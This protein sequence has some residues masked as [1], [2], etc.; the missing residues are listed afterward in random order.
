M[1]KN[2]VIPVL[3]VVTYLLYVAFGP[4]NKRVF[5]A[6][7]D[8]AK[9]KD[10]DKHFALK[11]CVRYFYRI[12]AENY[13][14]GISL[15]YNRKKIKYKFVWDSPGIDEEIQK[16]ISMQ[17]W[18][19]SN[20]SETRSFAYGNGGNYN[21]R[22]QID[23]LEELAGIAMDTNFYKVC[24]EHLLTV[25]K[26]CASKDNGWFYSSCFESQWMLYSVYVKEFIVNKSNNDVADMTKFKAP[27]KEELER[28]EK[29]YTFF[30]I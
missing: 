4:F 10:K 25:R 20:F 19:Y 22:E 28:I 7:D 18:P 14:K 5:T 23:F 2:V 13:E 15:S 30:G 29:Q 27:A 24:N 17:V 3:I 21:D 1:S 9:I 11:E 8:L 12:R 16:R 6:S 26:E